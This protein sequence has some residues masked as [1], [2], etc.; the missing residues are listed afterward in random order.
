M[1]PDDLH[2]GSAIAMTIYQIMPY[3]VAIYS[4]NVRCSKITVDVECSYETVQNN[5]RAFESLTSFS[6]E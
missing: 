1:M 2:K 6:V 3:F 5:Q 4:K